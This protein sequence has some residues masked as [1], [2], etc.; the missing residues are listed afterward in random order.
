MIESI[1]PARQH[2]TVTGLRGFLEFVQFVDGYVRTLATIAA[3]LWE[4]TK[5]PMSLLIR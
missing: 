1:L 3:P 5:K 2:E 4:L